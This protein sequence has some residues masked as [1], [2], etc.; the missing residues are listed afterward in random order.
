MYSKAKSDDEKWLH[1]VMK[2]ERKSHGE[3][4]PNLVVYS[5]AKCHEKL[6]NLDDVYIVRQN[7]LTKVK[8]IWW[9]KSIEFG[10]VQ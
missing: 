4:R 3:N 8:Q 6:T 7:V 5:R 9:W 10:D 2:S 1:L